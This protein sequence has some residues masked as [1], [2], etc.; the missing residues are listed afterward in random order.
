MQ[1]SSDKDILIF[2]NFTD[3][4]KQSRKTA[5]YPKKGKNY[6]YPTLGLVG[7]AGEVAEKIKKI[8]RNE[9]GKV[10]NERKKQLEKEM[11][12]VL[13]YLANLA[14]ELKLPLDQIA[15]KN[16]EKLTDRKKRGVLK[17]EGDER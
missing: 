2:M 7:E 16:I 3:Y 11:G 14:T 8:I 5:V 13:W 17:S 4:Q 1:L 6:I 12:D 15:K 9:K 10:S